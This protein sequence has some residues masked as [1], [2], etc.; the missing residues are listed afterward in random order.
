MK[1]NISVYRCEELEKEQ[2]KQGS[3]KKNEDGMKQYRLHTYIHTYKRRY[4]RYIIVHTHYPRLSFPPPYQRRTCTTVAKRS[5]TERKGSIQYWLQRC[6]AGGAR[7]IL[8]RAQPPLCAT[9]VL[10]GGGC[11]DR[12]KGLSDSLLRLPSS[13]SL[14][15]RKREKKNVRLA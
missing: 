7:R 8:R 10:A 12:G 9:S 15:S 2:R 4:I 5:Q 14:G 1:G 6:L 13:F 11:E 3:L